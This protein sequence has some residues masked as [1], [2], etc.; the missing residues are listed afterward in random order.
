MLSKLLFARGFCM[1]LLIGCQPAQTATH[2]NNKMELHI[3]QMI[4]ER[5]DPML[6]VANG[7]AL[8]LEGLPPAVLERA[9]ISIHGDQ[10]ILHQPSGGEEVYGFAYVHAPQAL[11]EYALELQDSGDPV[12]I[13]YRYSDCL[14]PVTCRVECHQAGL[15]FFAKETPIKNPKRCKR[16]R[17]D[18]LCTDTLTAVCTRQL[19]FDD[20]CNKP[21]N[22][23]FDREDWRCN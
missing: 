19:F 22:G 5:G 12:K 1:L 15:N 2:G 20:Q 18:K 9:G 6:V 4:E 3:R 23:P 7:T 11:L 21:V 17:E 8:L 16:I 10:L 13:T 14:T